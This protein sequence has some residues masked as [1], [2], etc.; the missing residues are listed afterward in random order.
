MDLQGLN[1][2]LVAHGVPKSI[3]GQDQKVVVRCSQH[4]T[5]IGVRDH[6]IPESRGRKKTIMSAACD[7]LQT[8]FNLNMK[9]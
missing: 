4:D 5:D 1:A 2:H 6:T 9:K 3:R 7:P 8:L